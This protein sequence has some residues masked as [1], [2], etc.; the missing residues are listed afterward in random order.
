MRC[1][2]KIMLEWMKMKN[3]MTIIVILVVSLWHSIA[4][5]K[6]Y[7]NVSNKLDMIIS[8]SEKGKIDSL[9]QEIMDIGWKYDSLT[10][11][12]EHGWEF[13]N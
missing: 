7:N 10:L 2:V 12:Y 1:L 8:V 13:T 5:N 9:Q 4:I 11:K 6:K 3:K